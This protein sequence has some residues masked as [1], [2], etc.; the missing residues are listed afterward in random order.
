MIVE[1][2]SGKIVRTLHMLS[3]SFPNSLIVIVVIS[4]LAATSSTAFADVESVDLPKDPDF[5]QTWITA[6]PE[7]AAV[8]TPTATVS[9]PKAV[10]T[11]P[12]VTESDRAALQ[13][14]ISA[15]LDQKDLLESKVADIMQKSDVLKAVQTTL[16]DELASLDEHAAQTATTIQTVQG[17]LDATRDSIDLINN[18]VLV[19]QREIAQQ[20]SVVTAYIQ[21][22]Y[23]QRD[24]SVL[25]MLLTNATF[26]DTLT[27]IENTRSL[28][29]T[30]RV[31]FANLKAAQDELTAQQ[32][33][34]ST[35]QG[36]LDKLLLTLQKEQNTLAQ[37][38]QEKRYLLEKTQGKEAQYQQLLLD[39]KAQAEQVERD[40]A[41]LSDDIAL[42][43]QSDQLAV[44]AQKYGEK[45]SLI[46]PESGAIWPV[47]ASYKGISAYF[48]D[49]GYLRLFGFPHSAIDI[50]QPGETPIRAPANAVVLKVVD[51]DDGGYNYVVLYHGTDEEGRDITTVY[52]HLPKIFIEKGDVVRQGEIIA[53]TGGSPGTRG[54][55]PYYTGPH[56]HFEV[57]Q[58]GAAIDPLK[59][60]P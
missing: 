1:Q 14:T 34:L 7:V 36:R 59:W 23:S 49:S 53:L 39:Y 22:V 21:A 40:I 50:P 12:V 41:S 32:E 2:N 45:F 52:G 38:E 17:E 27:D 55:G 37:Q 51:R 16:Q 33:N 5:V 35:K 31:L 25:D 60:L 57:R 43:K 56:L 10:N 6:E 15:T 46:N 3:R 18:K 24:I 13:N 9:K 48:R 42:F 47:D 26:A 44:I 29:D 8:P 58:N 4:T 20:K 11:Q 30:G 28:E 19:K 54:T